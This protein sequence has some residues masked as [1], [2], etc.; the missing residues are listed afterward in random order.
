MSD[1][2]INQPIKEQAAQTRLYSEIYAVTKDLAQLS[3]C[4][5][6]EEQQTEQLQHLLDKRQELIDRSMK[7]EPAAGDEARSILEKVAVLDVTVRKNLQQKRD[8]FRSE[9]QKIHT[10]KQAGRAYNPSRPQ[11]E[12][13]FIDTRKN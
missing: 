4:D 10:G 3:A 8:H 6:T 11:R 12:G 13:F 5:L 9:L 7:Q 1:Q 2:P